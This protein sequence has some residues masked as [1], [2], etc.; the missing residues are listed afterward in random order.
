MGP[1]CGRESSFAR[2]HMD[3][4]TIV[5]MEKSTTVCK[6]KEKMEII[7]TKQKEQ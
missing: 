2:L 3:Q 1:K 7:S 6:M 4:V 5:M